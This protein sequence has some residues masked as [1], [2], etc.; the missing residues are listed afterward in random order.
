MMKPRIEVSKKTLTQIS[1]KVELA[2]DEN[3]MRL[4]KKANVVL[5]VFQGIKYANLAEQFRICKDTIRLWMNDFYLRQM[6]SFIYKKPDGRNVRL[7]NDQIR[8]LKKIID[9]GPEEYGFITGVWSTII[10]KQVIFNEFN[11][12][13]SVQY[14]SAFLKNIGYSFQKAKFIA[15]QASDEDRNNWLLEVW[16][17]LLKKAE[18]NNDYILF[19]DEASFPQ[20]G[21]LSY[22]WSQKGCQPLVKTCGTRRA[23]KAFGAIEYFSGKFFSHG[24]VGKFNSETYKNFIF[25][26]LSKTKKFIHLIQDG[27]RYHTSQEMKDFFKQHKDRIKCYQLP[28][29]SPDYNPIEILWK[30][31]KKAGI[32]LR[33]FPTFDD[34]INKVTELL[35]TFENT[36]KEI[37]K[38]F[39]FYKGD[40]MK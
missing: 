14:L 17:D 6:E 30:K 20:W 35:A 8:N 13:Y 12:L 33:Y 24:I 16:P 10:I 28:S 31:I 4:F 1:K 19:G 21:T 25:Q 5:G 9:A 3:D 26:I 29:Y 7:N 32:H 22:T 34:L 18:K 23:F 38:V 15:A 37:L 36:P 39:G 27:A 2:F 11:V 40:E